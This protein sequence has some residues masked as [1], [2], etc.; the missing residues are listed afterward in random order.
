MPHFSCPICGNCRLPTLQ[1][2]LQHISRIHASSPSFFITC[3]LDGC[4]RTYKNNGSYQK[5]VKKMHTR[6]FNLPTEPGCDTYNHSPELDDSFEYSDDDNE[7][8]HSTIFELSDTQ[9]KQQKAK[10]IL[11][12]R[13]TNMLTQACTENLLSDITDI[14]ANIAED[15]KADVV[16]KLT[17][18]STTLP[19]TILK[20]ISEIFDD[21]I[22][23]QPF[24]G[25]ETQYKQLQFYRKHFNFVVSVLAICAAFVSLLKKNINIP[26]SWYIAIQ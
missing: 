14:F 18:A 22:Y 1:L 13:E 25:L 16:N 4:L 11:K 9:R 26:V 5:H 12:I 8:S 3:G 2:L 10:W 24:I 20:E 7:S 6:Y 21:E 17:T 15:L 23:R 19:S